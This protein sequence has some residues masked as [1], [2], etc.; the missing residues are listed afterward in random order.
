M[1]NP[2]D[3]AGLENRR[4]GLDLDQHDDDGCDRDRR[5]RVHHNAE[6]AMVGVVFDGMDVRHLDHCQQRQQDKAQHGYCRPGAWL[7]AAFSAEMCLQSCQTDDPCTK[8]TQD[9]MRQFR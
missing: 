1:T 7:S 8:D 6:R 4:G 2:G 5:S 3:D 9:S